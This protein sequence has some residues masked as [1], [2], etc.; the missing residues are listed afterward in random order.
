MPARNILLL[1]LIVDDVGGTNI[2]LNWNLY[3]HFRIDE[4]SLQLL[5]RQARKLHSLAVSLETWDESNYGKLINFCDRGSLE[6]VKKMWNFYGTERNESELS[7]FEEHFEACIQKSNQH[8]AHMGVGMNLTG[9]RSSNPA[10]LHSINDLDSLHNHYWQYGSVELNQSRLSHAVRANPMFASLEEHVVMHYGTDPLLGFHLATAFA[11]LLP[12]SPL[13]LSSAESKLGRVVEAAKSE[14][15]LWTISFRR[16]LKSVNLRFFVG[17]ALAFSHYLQRLNNAQWSSAPQLYRDRF[18]FEPLMLDGV[19]DAQSTN[20]PLKF[21][22]IDTSNLIDH[23]GAL[24]LLVATAPLLA[25]DVSATLYTEK[26]VRSDSTYISLF[27]GLLCGSLPTVS[28]LL[29]LTPADFVTNTSAISTGDELLLDATIQSVQDKT[30]ERGQL[31]TRNAWKRPI[32]MD[33]DL[34]DENALKRIKFDPVGLSAILYH[35]Y[36]RMFENEDV[37]QML[38]NVTM[39]KLQKFST[40]NYQR[41]SF[42]AFI[43]ILRITVSVDWGRTIDD[44][45]DRIGNNASHLMTKNYIQELY[46]WL[47]LFGIYSVDTLKRPLNSPGTDLKNNDLRDWKNIPPIVCVTLMVPRE[48]LAAFTKRDVMEIG[49]PPL[50]CLVQGSSNGRPW[51]NAFGAIQTGFGEV[52]SHGTPF[53]V[54]F[55]VKVIEDRL[56]WSGRSPLL[57]SFYA[58]TW[59]LLLQPRIASVELG[60]Q[61]TPQS[62][63][64]FIGTLGL[65]LTVYR[66]S[67]SDTDHVYI[68]KNLPNQ[69]ADLS[70]SNFPACDT[71]RP[72]GI[73]SPANT[74]ITAVVNSTMAKITSMTGRSEIVS[75]NHKN[76]LQA[77]GQVTSVS[78]TPFNFTVSVHP[79]LNIA[80]DFALPMLDSGLKIK[81]A[82]KSSYIELITQVAD[83]ADWPAFLS[84]TY[85]IFVDSDTI[86]NWNIPYLNLSLL[87]CLDEKQQARLAWLTTHTSMMFSASERSL[88]NNPQQQASTGVR[89]R[90][91]FKDSLFSFFMH[92]S[93]LQGRRACVFGL[94]CPTDGGV[95]I[96]FFVSCLR[97][98]L[99]NRTAVLDAAALPLYDILMPRIT[100]FLGKLTNSGSLCQIRVT[101]PEMH[102]WKQVLPAFVERCRTWTHKADCEYLTERRVP[103]SVEK[104]QRLLCSCGD[105]IMPSDYFR[106]VPEWDEVARYTVRTAISPCFSAPIFENGHKIEDLKK[107]AQENKAKLCAS[108]D[109][110]KAVNRSSLLICSRC[111]TARYCSQKCQRADWK[112][113]KKVCMST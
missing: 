80:V 10:G 103:L 104:G 34:I 12:T 19:I 75:T 61:S 29:G 21:T 82:R 99:S 110:D 32:R 68:S 79:G 20:S 90:V 17:D 100:S 94:N 47:H 50:H 83:P 91:E 64:A 66:T 52:M 44:L 97:L 81:V 59:M 41:A 107:E 16:H 102:L 1:S 111:H 25:H 49:T 3:Y 109:R 86:T 58:P 77:G 113:H 53:S 7:R 45:L 35:I 18:H 71:V 95:H 48:R 38:S 15:R 112:K 56:A 92:Y 4:A 57:V 62:T 40:P 87:P 78:K 55:E 14:F 89:T 69:S 84:F 13:F 73:D 28:M 27:E 8:K 30:V 74:T 101:E 26:L 42:V 43:S 72:D 6:K 23:L 67:L 93:G 33:N 9:F 108:C 31:F 11:P 60:I 98:D 70:I 65:Q 39:G 37:T 96:L 51:Q 106:G 76:T 5:Q 22:V 85:P 36:L 2:T 88:R 24:N 46:V 54:S 105:G 63:Q